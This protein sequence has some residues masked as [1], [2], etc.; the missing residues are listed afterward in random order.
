MRDASAEALPWSLT[1]GG[2][3]VALVGLGVLRSTAGA[4]GE[5]PASAQR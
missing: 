2:T 5:A 3:L 4:A 1:L